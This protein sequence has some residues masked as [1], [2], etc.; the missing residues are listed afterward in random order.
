MSDFLFV[1]IRDYCDRYGANIENI[2]EEQGGPRPLSGDTL[3]KLEKE[4][5]KTMPLVQLNERRELRDKR[6]GALAIHRHQ[7]KRENES[8]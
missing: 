3:D 6:L 7:E 8:L 1:G 4:L 5:S 2:C